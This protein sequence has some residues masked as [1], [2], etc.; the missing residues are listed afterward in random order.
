MKY[1]IE[2]KTE[3]S[4]ASITE[5]KSNVVQAVITADIHTEN[6]VKMQATQAIFAD[7]LLSGS[8]T[9]SRDEFLEAVNLLGASID[10]ELA[11]GRCTFTLRS[12]SKTFPK[13]LSLFEMMITQPTFSAAELK[14]VKA[15]AINQLHQAK[16]DSKGV[17]NEQ[18]Q[19]I[20]YGAG[21]RKFSYAIEETITEVSKLTK[22]DLKKLHIDT[23]SRKWYVT[24]GGE[25]AA[26][27]KLSTLVKRI[28]QNV[29]FSKSTAIH[30]P[31]P[32]K[33]ALALEHIPSKQNID[34][35]IGL[36]QPITNQHPD[37]LPLTFAVAILG[38]WGGFTGRLMSTVREKEGL[39]Y[40]IY[41]RLEGFVN[42]EQGH[43]RIVTF[44][45]PEKII[46]GLTATFREITTLYKKG[47]TAAEVEKF[48]TILN[49]QQTLLQDSLSR[50][51]ND[52]HGYHFQDYSLQEIA[53][54]KAQ[55]SKVILSDINRVI[56]TYLNPELFSVSAAGPVN[57]LQK[58]L[59]KWHQGV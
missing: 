17:A 3:Y 50:Q 38:K 14:R 59:K 19:N 51:I 23:L 9:L 39:T 46:Q 41:A 53:E 47:V 21:D 26:V 30:Q 5:E 43:L 56:T 20:F 32:P 6:T 34:L 18:L 36:P 1:H 27:T 37:F 44:F 49:T 24:I 29:E 10:I 57:S 55:L 42:D 40:G 15:T 13:L 28:K 48:K 16:E 7:A 35:S 25:K 54:Q 31:L 58:E 22:G 45:P 12:T 4:I 52:L 33:P 8:G 2:P 11:A